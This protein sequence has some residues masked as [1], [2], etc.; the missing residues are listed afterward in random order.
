[1]T[2]SEKL[3][4]AQNLINRELQKQGVDLIDAMNWEQTPLDRATRTHRMVLFRGGRSLYL[5]SQRPRFSKTTGPNSRRRR[6]GTMKVI[7]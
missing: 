2:I 1:M 3:R 7:Y 6:C 5:P 4:D